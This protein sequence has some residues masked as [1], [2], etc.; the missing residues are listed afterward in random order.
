M[1]SK[2]IFIALN[3]Q[4]KKRA[5][6]FIKM[7]ENLHHYIQNICLIW[8]MSYTY[9]HHEKKIVSSINDKYIVYKNN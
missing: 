9:L 6:N 8:N 2:C 4:K 1:Q 3:E 5:S 7:L